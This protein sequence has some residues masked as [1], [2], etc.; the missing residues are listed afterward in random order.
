M[1]LSKETVLFVSQN[2]ELR[3]KV[4]QLVRLNHK[5]C[6]TYDNVAD[7]IGAAI[8]SYT[9]EIR[10]GLDETPQA[11]RVLVLDA[12][13]M[14]EQSA[15]KAALDLAKFQGPTYEGIPIL[16]IV[17]D[18]RQSAILS[19]LRIGVIEAE[20]SKDIAKDVLDYVNQ[21]IGASPA[22]GR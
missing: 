17:K 4:D 11:V 8:V 2:P 1:P 9:N 15:R 14:D 7:A 10:F 6:V 18:I 12:R 13:L 21:K 5:Q 22:V 3:Q 16:A 20:P 19:Q